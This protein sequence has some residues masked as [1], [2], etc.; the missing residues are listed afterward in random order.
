MSILIAIPSKGRPKELFKDTYSFIKHSKFDFK[1]FIEPQDHEEYLEFFDE[2]EIVILSENNR[3]L[4]FS[5]LE[6]FEYCKEKK[7]KYVFKMDDDI[8]NLRVRNISKIKE[9]NEVDRK[10]RT[11]NFLDTAI[12]NSLNLLK[13]D[14]VKGISFPY[15]NELRIEDENILFTHFNKR[16][17]SCY[18][19]DVDFLFPYPEHIYNQCFEDFDTF[20][21]IIDLGYLIIRYEQLGIDCRPVGSNKGGIQSFNRAKIFQKTYEVMNKRYPYLIWKDVNKE[22]KKEPDLRRTKE[23]QSIKYEF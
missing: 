5:K 22:W 16:F 18:L 10:F 4:C 15:G 8:C 13:K 17:Q 11:E 9:K 19:V 20:F 23:F 3:G 7:Y 6:I 1:I 2:K 12:A 14:R 21:N